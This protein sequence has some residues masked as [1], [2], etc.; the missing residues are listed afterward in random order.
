MLVLNL[1]A[2]SELSLWIKSL[3]K[4]ETQEFERYRRGFV[5][6]LRHIHLHWKLLPYLAWLGCS[7]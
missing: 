6:E 2:A 3:N 1:A 5:L 4:E 7:Q